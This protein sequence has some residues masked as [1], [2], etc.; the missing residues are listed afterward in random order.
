[1]KLDHGSRML[2]VTVVNDEL[3]NVVV[4]V[5]VLRISS[6]YIS[7]CLPSQVFGHGHGVNDC[8]QHLFNSSIECFACSYNY[9]TFFPDAKRKGT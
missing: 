6:S 3:L 9:L 5:V 4:V 1:M 8:V 2:Q 7:D